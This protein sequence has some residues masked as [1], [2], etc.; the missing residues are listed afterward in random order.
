M[1]KRM[2]EG[3]MAGEATP[4]SWEM[5]ARDAAQAPGP[6]FPV[7]ACLEGLDASAPGAVSPTDRLPTRF[8]LRSVA[9]GAT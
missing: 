1:E 9:E 5:E 8:D 3:S 4:R 6:G 2:R 7:V